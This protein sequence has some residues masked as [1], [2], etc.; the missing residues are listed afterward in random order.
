M[1]THNAHT[2][3]LHNATAVNCGLIWAQTHSCTYLHLTHTHTQTLYARP[4]SFKHYGVNNIKWASQL[5]FGFTYPS[6]SISSPYLHQTPFPSYTVLFSSLPSILPLPHS[7]LPVYSS[8]YIRYKMSMI[9]GQDPSF[10][11]PPQFLCLWSITS[12]ERSI[13]IANRGRE[14]KSWL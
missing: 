8:L 3:C 6:L 5:S 2:Q 11:S 12:L 10:P 4:I 9:G 14:R 13:K 7:F 1:L